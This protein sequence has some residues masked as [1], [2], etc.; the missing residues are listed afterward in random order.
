LFWQARRAFNEGRYADAERDFGVFFDRHPENREAEAAML[1]AG[2]AAAR[3]QEYLGAIEHFTTLI[4]EFPQSARLAEA[5][6]E[7]GNALSA[8]AKFSEAILVYQELVNRYPESDAVAET[9]LRIGDCQFMLGQDDSARYT[10][11]MQA[12][13]AAIGSPHEGMDLDLQAE[14]KIGRCLQKLERPEE[15]IHQFY[16]RVMLRFLESGEKGLPQT[17]AGRTW[18]GLASRDA[19]DILEQRGEW[20]KLV[21]ILERA[22]DAGVPG[23][24]AVRER[25]RTIRSQHW[26]LFY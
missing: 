6:L 15:A 18:F 23:E 5:R 1:W 22:A 11:A 21:S 14:Y 17:E 19:A 20:R 4:K 24:A 3:R 10:A 9:W 25:I 7:Q 13:R 2:R 12:Y 26:W 8:L 16:K